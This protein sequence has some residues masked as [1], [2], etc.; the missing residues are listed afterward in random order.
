M[1]LLLVDDEKE[2]VLT[3]AE[4]LNLRGIEADYAF[5]G[6][7]AIKKVEE[8]PF[9]V[10]VLDMRLP[11]MGGLALRESLKK[12]R[13]GMKFLFLTGYG[14]EE[15]FKSVSQSDG[16][17]AYLVKPVEIETLMKVIQAVA[18]GGGYGK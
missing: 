14:T 12:V 10:A 2:F 7:D 3:L 13:P 17:N 8:R 5:S 4:R 6:E 11:R 18:E 15:D 1:R 9:D 16:E